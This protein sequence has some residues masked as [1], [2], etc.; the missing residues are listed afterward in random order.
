MPH[1][2]G[3]HPRGAGKEETN[4]LADMLED[5]VQDAIAVIPDDSSVEIQEADKTSSAEIYD[6]L[7]DKMNAEI[8]KAIL[9]QTLTNEMGN[10]GSQRRFSF[11]SKIPDAFIGLQL[12]PPKGRFG[13]T[14][15]FPV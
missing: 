12:L 1:F 6:K 4:P 15:T 13:E 5:M 10:T 14:Q 3:K 11:F 8:S 9:G 7:I 2:I